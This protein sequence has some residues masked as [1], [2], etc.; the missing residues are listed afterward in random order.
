MAASRDAVQ[1]KDA[2]LPRAESSLFSRVS[3]GRISEIIVE[4]IRLLIQQGQ[5][6]PGDRLPPE[7][8]L[9]ERFGVSRVTVRE[10][11]RMLESSG[12]VEIRVGARGGAFVTAPTSDRVG[13]GLAQLLSMSVISA[14]DV[15]EVRMVLEVGI[16]PLVC[17]RATE[18]DLA[19]LEKICERSENAL[20]TDDYSMDISLEFHIRVAQATHNP[21][22]VMLIESFRG[23]I[24]MSLQEAKEAAPEMGAVGTKEHERFI[25]AVRAR[26]VDS[27]TRIMREH[28]ERTAHR[29]GR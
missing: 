20:R 14:A 1:A 18:E 12:L 5:L 19:D 10:A 17:E 26:D 22:I 29:V 6:S 3:V 21:A 7:R 2:A 23:P 9:C 24:L 4:Q 8:D 15:T 25:E 16:V 28:L 27:A 13:E 11:L